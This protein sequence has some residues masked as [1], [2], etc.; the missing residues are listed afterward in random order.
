ML[1]HYLL[2][3]LGGMLGSMARFGLA[4]LMHR[5]AGPHNT[6]PIGT[7][8]VN[9]VGCLLIGLLGGLMDARGLLGPQARLLLMVGVLGGFTTFS[10][11][12]YETMSLLREGDL[13]RALLNVGVQVVVGLLA[14]WAGLMAART[15]GP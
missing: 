14:V 2:V 10:S 11:F 15:I 3:G 5:L 13:L 9:L 8:T 1:A 4:G 12:G 6:F 7:L